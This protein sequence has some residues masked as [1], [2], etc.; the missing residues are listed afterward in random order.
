MNQ[1]INRNSKQTESEN[2]SHIVLPITKKALVFFA[3][4]ITFS[5]VLFWAVNHTAK[6][7]QVFRFTLS[8]LSPF[9]IGFCIAFVLNMI[10]HPLEVFWDMIWIKKKKPWKDKLKRPICLLSSVLLLISAIFILIFLILPELER[11][12]KTFI[13]SLPDYLN[14]FTAWAGSLIG[15]IEGFGFSLPNVS[16][17]M[18]KVMDLANSFIS[19]YGESVIDKTVGITSSIVGAVVDF[20]LAFVFSIYLL[21][22]KEH[23]SKQVKKALYA[24]FPKTKTD[25]FIALTV[26]A[27]DTFTKFITGQLTE[28]AIIGF[29]C[30]IGMLIFRIPYAAVVSVLVGVTALIPIFGAFVGTAVGAFLILLVSPIKA[31]WFIVFILV[32]QQLEGNLIYPKVVGKSVGLPG[33][34]VLSAVTIGGGLFG[35]PGM[36]FSVPVSSVLYCLYK[37]FIE[38]RLKE[39]KINEDD[40]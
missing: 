25:K 34:L 38:K 14:N 37:E 17:D 1:E 18:D 7:I 8:L 23:I 15:Y 3:L 31:F 21:A 26:L 27:K 29:L 12:A 40:L 30:F 19:D 33:I 36:L 4:L 6:L 10:L 11:T 28:A 20:F 39:R 22:Q 24:L 13:D 5:V 16:F 9:L 32:L 2:R 35:M